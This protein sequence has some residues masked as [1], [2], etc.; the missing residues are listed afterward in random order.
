MITVAVLATSEA[1]RAG[2]ARLLDADPGLDVVSTMPVDLATADVLGTNHVDVILMDLAADAIEATR[3]IVAKDPDARI[4]I[5]AA[6]AAAHQV[7]A[8]IDAGAIGFLL[9]DS[10]PVL[11]HLA[12]RAAAHGDCPI[13]PRV[14]RILVNDRHDRHDRATDVQL[15]ERGIEILRLAAEGLLNKQIARRL[16][17]SEKTVKAHLTRVYERLGVTH[18]A[19]AI[20]LARKLAIIH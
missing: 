6:Q 3:R 1:V 17:I 4:V 18:R 10:A 13:D 7:L 15:S 14:A 20:E 11:L 9:K 5:L 2:I 12:V 8:V 16:G 19:E